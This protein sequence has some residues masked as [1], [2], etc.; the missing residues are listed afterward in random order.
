VKA[1]CLVGAL[2]GIIAC[3]AHYTVAPIS[4]GV[5]GLW[6][7]VAALNAILLVIEKKT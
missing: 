1:F 4:Y 3:I 7:A 2:A 6:P 5:A